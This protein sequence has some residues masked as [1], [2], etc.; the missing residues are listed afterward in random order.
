MGGVIIPQNAV[1]ILDGYIQHFGAR[2]LENTAKSIM[3]TGFGKTLSWKSPLLFPTKT[4]T[5]QLQRA[6]HRYEVPIVQ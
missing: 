3:S 5:V 1:L 2:W 6:M 4:A